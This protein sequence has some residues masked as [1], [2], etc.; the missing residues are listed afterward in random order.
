MR[1]IISHRVLCELDDAANTVTCPSV[2]GTHFPLNFN[3]KSDQRPSLRA[4]D[5]SLELE[6]TDRSDRVSSNDYSSECH[7]SISICRF[8]KGC[9]RTILE[10][11]EECF[12]ILLQYNSF[13]FWDVNSCRNVLVLG[14]SFWCVILFLSPLFFVAY[15]FVQLRLGL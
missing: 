6:L 10:I 15:C 4:S 9:G 13:C 11:L 1:Y 3:R 14:V 12:N 8:R 2:I 5:T 7:E